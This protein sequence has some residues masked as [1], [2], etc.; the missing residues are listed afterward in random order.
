MPRGLK[1]FTAVEVHSRNKNIS[2]RDTILCFERSVK[3]KMSLLWSQ[4]LAFSTETY[5]S[6]KN[7]LSLKHKI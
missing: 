2:A 6:I 7:R 5:A 1:V 3:V 4:G